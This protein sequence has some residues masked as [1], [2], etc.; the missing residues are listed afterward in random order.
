MTNETSSIPILRLGTRRS[1]LALAQAEEARARLCAAHGWPQEAVELVPV[2]AGGDKIQDRPLADI[3]GK[4]LWTRELDLCLLDGRIDGA[5]HSMKDV[6]TARPS[7]LAIG[8]ILPRADRRDVLVGARGIAAIPQGGRVGTSAPRRA[9]QMRNLRPD[10]EVVL[11]RGNVGTRLARLAA[12]EA[13]VT[14][15]AR[16]G[17]DR[18]GETGVGTPLEPEEF[19]PAPAQGAIGIECRAGDERVRGLLAAI[20]HAPSRAEIDAERG[21]LAQL[22][23]TCHSPVAVDC[24]WR[25][26]GRLRMRAALFSPDGGLRVDGEC[27]LAIGDERRLAGFAADL[28]ER[29]APAIQAVFRGG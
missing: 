29:A 27:L 23:G 8:A 4:A 17:L 28:L 16:A 3:G 25:G 10:L 11:F 18:L 1:P 6:E 7:E 19:L 24:R 2:I 26:D 12:G 21:L 20:D 14:L 5:V 22:E 9:A 13:E 15:L